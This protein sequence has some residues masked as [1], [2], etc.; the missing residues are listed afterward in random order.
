MNT[1]DV[2]NFLSDEGLLPNYAFPGRESSFGPSFIVRKNPRRSGAI[3]REIMTYIYAVG[4]CCTHEARPGQHLLCGR[5]PSTI[6]QVDVFTTESE[7]WRLCPNCSHAERDETLSHVAS[8]PRCGSIGWG[9]AGQ[10][11]PMLKVKM[12]YATDDYAKSLIADDAE[13]RQSVFYLREMLIDVDEEKDIISAYQVG[14]DEFPFG[15]EFV[16]KATLREINF[17]EKDL[18]GE[19]LTVS[20]REEVRKGFVV[21]RYCG[22]IQREGQPPNHALTCRVRRQALTE[23]YEECIFSI[24]K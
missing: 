18:M 20:G 7:Q 15:Y 9:D 5:A 12:V 22:K 14:T 10:V 24:G 17:G 3:A 8:C 6:D 1:K 4:I 2:F 19:H 16:Q 21:C 13:D 23:P 11:R